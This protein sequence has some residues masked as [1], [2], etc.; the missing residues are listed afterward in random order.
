LEKIHRKQIN[1]ACIADAKYV[2]YLKR[3]LMSL[4]NSKNVLHV[5][6][7]LINI[8]N[9][10][11][12]I[13]KCDILILATEWNESLNPAITELLKLRLTPIFDGSNILDKKKLIAQNIEYYGVGR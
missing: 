1:L 3:L 11:Q 6:I 9:K 12:S 13:H 8:R 2:K 10:Y 7:C 4:G 5:D